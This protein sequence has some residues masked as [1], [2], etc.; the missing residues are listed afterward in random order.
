ML[1]KMKTK[2]SQN[3]THETAAILYSCYTDVMAPF[4]AM[5]TFLKMEVRITASPR[6]GIPFITS[7]TVPET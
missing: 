5:L 2:K 1:I 6:L 3:E 7:S 4:A